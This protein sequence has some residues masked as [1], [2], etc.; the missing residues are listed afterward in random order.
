MAGGLSGVN[1]LALYFSPSIYLLNMGQGGDLGDAE[2]QTE[3]LIQVD[4]FLERCRVCVTHGSLN[5]KN[6]FP[7]SLGKRLSFVR[8]NSLI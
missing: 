6:L 2:K 1:P 5:L 7:L 4:A 3:C 8:E